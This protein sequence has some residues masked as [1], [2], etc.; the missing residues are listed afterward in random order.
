[1]AACPTRSSR[2]ALVRDRPEP[3]ARRWEAVRAAVHAQRRTK[4]NREDERSQTLLFVDG[5]VLARERLSTGAR[6]EAP[7]KLQVHGGIRPTDVPPVDHAREQA[8]AR[9]QQSPRPAPPAGRR[10]GRRRPAPLPAGSDTRTMA[11]GTARSDVRCGRV[12]ARTAERAARSAAIRRAPAGPR[13]WLS[14]DAESGTPTAP[15]RP[16]RRCPTPRRAVVRSSRRGQ[17]P[18]STRSPRTSSSSMVT[19]A[20]Q[21]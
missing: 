21:R 13:G 17:G 3:R 6:E 4:I 8:A 10:R 5:P 11:T 20:C 12:P 15:R 18:C 9:H 7:R 16:I 14:H 19:S 2:R 1:M